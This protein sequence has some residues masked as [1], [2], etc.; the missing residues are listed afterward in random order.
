M[1]AEIVFAT[2]NIDTQINK[3]I[4]LIYKE[5]FNYTPVLDKNKKVVGVVTPSSLINLLQNY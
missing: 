4:A 2:V 3:V 5:G 1:N